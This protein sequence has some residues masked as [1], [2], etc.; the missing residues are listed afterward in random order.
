M[1]FLVKI[2]PN[3]KNNAILGFKDDCLI[4]SVKEPPIEGRANEALAKLIA[5]RLGIAKG[6]IKLLK[7]TKS[8]LKK[9][10]IGCIE[11]KEITSILRRISKNA[12][13]RI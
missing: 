1:V 12:D 3:A 13:L 2:K 10:E 11:E 6:C 5:K 8:K 9:I 7:G 4:V